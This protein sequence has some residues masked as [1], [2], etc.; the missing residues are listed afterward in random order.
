[1]MSEFTGR[2]L[3]A[4]YVTGRRAWDVDSDGTLVSPINGYHWKPGMNH[5]SCWMSDWFTKPHT[6]AGA[7]CGC[8]FY[9]FTRGMSVYDSPGRVRGII[10]GKGVATC[11]TKGFRV[12]QA[13]VVALVSPRWSNTMARWAWFLAFGGIL[14]DVVSLTLLHPSLPRSALL[15]LGVLLWCVGIWFGMERLFIIDPDERRLSRRKVAALRERYPDVKWYGSMWR[16]RRAFPL[17]QVPTLPKGKPAP[18]TWTAPKVTDSKDIY[19]A[20]AEAAVDS[21]LWERRWLI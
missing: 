13:E 5:A 14:A 21:D 17:S 1:M 10:R 7:D 18:E 12:E 4:D 20:T 11:G 9:A 6:I 3:V 8:G 15:G 16:A 2:P 19:T